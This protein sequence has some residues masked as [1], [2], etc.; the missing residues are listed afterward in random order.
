L[1][2]GVQRRDHAERA[3]L[4]VNRSIRNRSPMH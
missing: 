1:Y 4:F 3:H 2:G